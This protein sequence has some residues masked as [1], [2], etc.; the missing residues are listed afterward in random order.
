MAEFNLLLKQ[1]LPGIYCLPSA[2]SA[3]TWFGVLFIRQG[4]YQEGVFRYCPPPG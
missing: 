2:K 4:S 1:K 3:L